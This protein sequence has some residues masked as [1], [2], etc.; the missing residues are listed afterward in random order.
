M[1]RERLAPASE[2]EG[3]RADW[4]EKSLLS[5]PV[6]EVGEIFFFLEILKMD[7]GILDSN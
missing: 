1:N 3:E 4:R 2:E 6:C 7:W 5:C